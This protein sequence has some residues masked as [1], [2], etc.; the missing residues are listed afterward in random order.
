MTIYFVIYFILLIFAF[1]ERIDEENEK[2]GVLTKKTIFYF[3]VCILIL[4]GGLRYQT[5]PDYSAYKIFYDCYGQSFSIIGRFE[6]GYQIFTHICKNILNFDF[7]EFLFAFTCVSIMVKAV[8]FY[9]YFKYPILLL[10]LYFPYLF[11]FA[12]FGQIRQ[13][14]AVGIIFWAL[15]A[16]Q[17]KKIIQFYLIW[18]LACSFHFS[19]FIFFPFYFLGRIHLNLRWF[20]ILLSLTF[21]ANVLSLGARIFQ[22]IA[23]L[24]S[25]SLIGMAIDSVLM[26]SLENTGSM[27]SLIT[28]FFAPNTL[29]SFIFLFLF[30]YIYKNCDNKKSNTFP[31]VIYNVE[32]FLL[33]IVKLFLSIKAI[34][35]RGSYFYKALEIFFFYYIGE[36]IKEKESK[37]FYFLIIF[38]YGI[39]RFGQIIYTY[40]EIYGNYR[41]Y[42]EFLGF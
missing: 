6:P 37:A 17:N 31:A 27:S 35:A 38:V 16:I 22:I 1:I 20:F 15:P 34:E 3:L 4:F 28:Y 25:N 12:D 36:N 30:A 33:I 19:A 21:I 40:P 10:M 23:N 7:T 42:S 41:I 39:L 13:G 9:K 29:L 8:F 11:L 24:F 2:T 14:M 32:I 5:G 26:Y 18:L